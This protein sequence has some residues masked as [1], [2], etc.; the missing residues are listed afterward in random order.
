MPVHLVGEAAKETLVMTENTTLYVEAEATHIPEY[1][2][3]SIE[4]LE[5][6]TQILANQITLPEGSTLL[7]DDELLIVNIIEAPTTEEV[8]AE[9]VEAEAEAGIAKDEAEVPEVG[10]ESA[11][12]SS[13][14]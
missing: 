9:L 12:G 5:A 11:E 1:F 6:G 13:G 14:E 8:E 10:E 7:S 4:G 2:E 3:V